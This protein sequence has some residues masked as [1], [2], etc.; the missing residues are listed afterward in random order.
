MV[1][2][3]RDNA[4]LRYNSILLLSKRDNPDYYKELI[5]NTKI[6]LYGMKREDLVL[7]FEEQIKDNIEKKSG[8][9]IDYILLVYKNLPHLNSFTKNRLTEEYIYKH[10]LQKWFDKV[11]EWV[12]KK[13]MILEQDIR[14]VAPPKQW[15]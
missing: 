3:R 1:L 10:E 6:F 15:V 14:F 8:S 2:M 12:F 13:L 4:E 7:E 9:S 11:E 5:R